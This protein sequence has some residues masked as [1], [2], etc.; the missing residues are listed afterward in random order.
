MKGKIMTSIADMTLDELKQLIDEAVDRRLKE[1]FGEFEIDEDEF[2]DDEEPDTRT[3]EEVYESIDRNM[4]TPP[5][6]A[7]TS[8]E[9]LREDRDR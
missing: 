9:L 3:L 7:K 1:L 6:G 8:L 4:W 2:F 5:Q